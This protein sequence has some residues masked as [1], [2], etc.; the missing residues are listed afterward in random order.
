MNGE[1]Q[2][3]SG[4]SGHRLATSF[5]LV[6]PTWLDQLAVEAASRTFVDDDA[7]MQWVVD[8]ARENVRRR[9]GGPF[10]AAVFERS[11]GRLVS[12]GANLVVTSRASIAHAEMVALTLAQQGRG[13]HDLGDSAG[14]PHELFTSTEPCAM[15]LGAIPWSGVERVVCSATGEDAEAIGF[16]E[17][18]KPDRWVE[19]L[20]AR[21]I[22]VAT[23]VL[24]SEGRAVLEEYKA[25]G[26]VIY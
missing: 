16:D 26:G 5:E 23:A 25:S 1:P 18:A 12:V 19:T 17:G 15:C 7:K 14:E 2:P 24:R 22:A 8:L 3:S 13:S 21:G 11:T 10:A 20:E 4:K 9:S 6:L